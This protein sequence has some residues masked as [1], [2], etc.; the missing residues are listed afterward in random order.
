VQKTN[1]F[2]GRRWKVRKWKNAGENWLYGA[3]GESPSR[4]V[5]GSLAEMALPKQ[6]PEHLGQE[7]GEGKFL[8]RLGRGQSGSKKKKEDVEKDGT[9]QPQQKFFMVCGGKRVAPPWQSDGK[10]GQSL[11]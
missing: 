3:L 7:G 11:V 1:A 2:G 5:G 4:G 10:G 8:R 6:Q 9:E